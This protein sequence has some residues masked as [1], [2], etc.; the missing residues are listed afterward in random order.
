MELVIE[1]SNLAQKNWNILLNEM[2]I[3]LNLKK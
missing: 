1:N 2:K 3:D